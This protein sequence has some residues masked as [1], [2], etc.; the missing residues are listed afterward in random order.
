MTDKII[1]SIC[2]Q[3][4]PIT[5]TQKIITGRVLKIHKLICGD[6]YDWGKVP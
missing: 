2:F 4:F 1:K 6:V 3:P 5:Q